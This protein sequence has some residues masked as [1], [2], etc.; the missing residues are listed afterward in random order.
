M[1][2]LCVRV[3]VWV[4]VCVCVCER[5]REREAQVKVAPASSCVSGRIDHL[6]Q[7]K[8]SPSARGRDEL[9]TQC[10]IE[11]HG[12]CRALVSGQE[13]LCLNIPPL[14]CFYPSSGEDVCHPAAVCAYASKHCIYLCAWS[15]GIHVDLIWGTVG[16]ERLWHSGKRRKT[17]HYSIRWILTHYSKMA[18]SSAGQ[19]Q[20]I[21]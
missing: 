14:S 21:K 16:W 18:T 13:L 4:C 15:K 6:I 8:D 7:I 10:K 19:S 9:V 12:H 5:E 2:S 11:N 3:C 17:S 20:Q 1:L